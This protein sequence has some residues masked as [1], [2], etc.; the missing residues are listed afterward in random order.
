MERENIVTRHINSFHAPF[1]HQCGR[2]AIPVPGHFF[3]SHHLFRHSKNFEYIF[4]FFHALLFSVVV[5]VV[6]VVV[7]AAAAVVVV[8]GGG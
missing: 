5:V 4:Y 1:G 7:V 2:Y 6:V 8:V 3:F